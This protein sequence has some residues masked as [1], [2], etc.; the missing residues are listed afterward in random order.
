MVWDMGGIATDFYFL[1]IFLMVVTVTQMGMVDICMK[2]GFMV[3]VWQTY[4]WKMGLWCGYDRYMHGKWVC[5]VGM[6]LL[7]YGKWICGAAGPIHVWPMVLRP[8]VLYLFIIFL[9]FFNF[10]AKN[11][12]FKILILR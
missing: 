4:A 12:I 5:S 9:F 6:T 10:D 7:Q 8:F 2:N 1:F 3:W 11:L